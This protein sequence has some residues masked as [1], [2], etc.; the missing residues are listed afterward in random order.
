MQIMIDGTKTEI[1]GPGGRTTATH[2]T[3]RAAAVHALRSALQALGWRV[4]GPRSTD[5]FRLPLRLKGEKMGP[6]LDASRW[7]ERANGFVATHGEKRIKVDASGDL[8]IEIE[9]EIGGG[10]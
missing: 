4:S 3:E 10:Q 6:P 1:D 8:P 9:I 5:R 2:I 7:R